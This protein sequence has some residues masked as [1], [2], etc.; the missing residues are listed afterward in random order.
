MHEI[1]PDCIVR[2][3]VSETFVKQIISTL[4]GQLDKF[5]DKAGQSE[6]NEDA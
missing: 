4:Q 6:Q 3:V 2:M 5:A 1:V